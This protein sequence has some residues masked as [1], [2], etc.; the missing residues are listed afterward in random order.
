V[1]K[2]KNRTPGSR[3]WD[4]IGYRRLY[5]SDRTWYGAAFIA[6]GLG[7]LSQLHGWW[8]ALDVVAALIGVVLVRSGVR[9]ALRRRDAQT[10]E[11]RP[12]PPW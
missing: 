2:D 5:V 11:T 4:F 10:D 7:G 9:R 1:V 3:W 12:G 6:G 8:K